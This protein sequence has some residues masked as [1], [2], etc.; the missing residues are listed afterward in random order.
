MS[1]CA[2]GG[3]IKERY[4]TMRTYKRIASVRNLA[5]FTPFLAATPDQPSLAALLAA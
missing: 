2:I 3:W 4:H 5:Q 1:P